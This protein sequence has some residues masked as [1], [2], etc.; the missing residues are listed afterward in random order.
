MST[1]EVVL[2]TLTAVLLATL[3]SGAVGC[4]N[5]SFDEVVAALTVNRPTVPAYDPAVLPDV[6]RFQISVRLRLFGLPSL[7]LPY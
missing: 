3:P 2:L 4:F 6:I 5:T 7:S 1:R